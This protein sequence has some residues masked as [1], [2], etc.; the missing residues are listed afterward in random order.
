[1]EHHL[2]PQQ[3][4]KIVTSL[5]TQC[6]STT[7][8]PSYLRLS[9]FLTNISPTRRFS[10]CGN[11]WDTCPNPPC[12]SLRRVKRHPE[13]HWTHSRPSDLHS[14]LHRRVIL[15]PKICHI[16]CIHQVQQKGTDV[17]KERSHSQG[18]HPQLHQLWSHR[19]WY[20]E[21]SP[22]PYQRHMVPQ[23]Q[24]VLYLLHHS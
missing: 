1:M 17:S 13:H 14:R 18:P 20:R 7:F 10:Y 11:L 19:T 23:T 9:K 12:H 2:L 6:C 4:P 8:P 16:W 15:P 24:V 3:N 22:Q 21:I 5:C